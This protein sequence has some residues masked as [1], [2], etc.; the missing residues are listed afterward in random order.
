[1]QKK[2]GDFNPKLAHISATN[3]YLMVYEHISKVFDV[4][5]GKYVYYYRIRGQRLDADGK[6]IGIAFDID[7][8]PFT[9]TERRNPDVYCSDSSS[10]YC[11]VVWEDG[12][13]SSMAIYGR[14]IPNTSGLIDSD[15]LISSGN[16]DQRFPAVAYG[17]GYYMV[18]WEHR[19]QENNQILST[20]FQ[21]GH[22][23]P[24][25]EI[26]HY[27]TRTVYEQ[28][29]DIEY[30]PDS[31]NFVI[32]FN[33]ESL[34]LYDDILAFIHPANSNAVLLSYYNIAESDKLKINPILSYNTD[35]KE[36]LIAFI[37]RN[38]VKFQRFGNIGTSPG[39]VGSVF[40]IDNLHAPSRISMDWNE[41]R[42]EFLLGVVTSLYSQQYDGQGVEISA[43]G[44]V[45]GPFLLKK[46]ADH[47]SVSRSQ[48]G[49]INAYEIYT[50]T[51][52]G[53]ELEVDRWPPLPLPALYYLLF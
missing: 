28:R 38:S 5:S 8:T 17:N 44:D 24:T 11:L 53:L 15:F 27:N 13:Y 16:T 20:I 10:G 1:M 4:Y 22:Q 3:Q 7:N 14:Y 33:V 35:K 47:I 46:D 26:I 39:N 2:I 19:E 31:K 42:K 45:S 36:M 23:I 41:D 34:S 9:T 30:D 18:V 52:V 51:I 29:P 48:G 50:D 40:G 49:W 43:T 6:P 32:V 25:E 21:Y 37:A 12:R